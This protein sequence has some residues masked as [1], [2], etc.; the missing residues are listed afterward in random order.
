MKDG[1]RLQ[2]TTTE[3]TDT[4]TRYPL[5]AHAMEQGGRPQQLTDFCPDIGVYINVVYM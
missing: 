5:G 1:D 4:N 3:T 2:V